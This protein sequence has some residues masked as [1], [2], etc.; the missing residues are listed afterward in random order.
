MAGL[1]PPDS[2]L[3]PFPS[4]GAVLAGGASRRFGEPKALAS[5]GGVRLVDRVVSA[6]REVVRDPVLITQHPERFAHLGLPAR[7]DLT[8]H[9]GPLAGVQTALRWAAEL[10]H[11]GALVVACDMPFVSAALLRRV[12]EE[13]AGG[14]LAV[15]PESAS[16]FGVEPLCA[17]YSVAL[18]E[19]V[20]Q[21][22]RHGERA[23]GPLLLESGARRI[24]LQEVERIAAPEVLFFNVNTRA[25]QTCAEEIARRGEEQHGER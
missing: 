14:A 25:D 15:A 11:D 1:A 19:P 10:G 21:R 12:L 20:E 16:R 17:W 18:L 6:V 13:A 3:P 22:L 8:P 24:P 2:V 9:G 4:L 5:V 23:L 7:P